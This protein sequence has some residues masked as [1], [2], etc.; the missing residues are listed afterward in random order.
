MWIKGRVCSFLVLSVAHLHGPPDHRYRDYMMVYVQL[1]FFIVDR[2]MVA[3]VWIEH[4][5]TGRCGSAK[6]VLTG[7]RRK[8]YKKICELGHLRDLGHLLLFLAAWGRHRPPC[9]Q[10]AIGV[11]L[12]LLCWLQDLERAHQGLVH[13]HHRSCVVKLAAVVG[14]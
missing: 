8:E 2:N 9:T 6:G 3:P 12:L 5:R 4:G 10:G 7:M 1:V 13:T 14:C 11:L